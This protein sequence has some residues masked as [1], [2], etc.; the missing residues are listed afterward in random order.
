MNDQLGHRGSKF[1]YAIVYKVFR[2]FGPHLKKY[3]KSFLIAYAALV[4]AVLMNLVKPWPLKLIFDYILLDEPMPE[5]VRNVTIHFGND[6][7]VLL[8]IFCISIVIVVFLH[9]FFT[10]TRRYLMASA[11]QRTINDIRKRVFD[12]LHVLPQSF[13]SSSRSGDLVL[14]LTSDINDLKKLLIKSVESIATNVLTFGCTVFVM[15][16]MDWQLTLLAL[17]IAPSLYIISVRVSG[18]VETLT[19]EQRSKESEVASVVQESM[20][21]MP[22]VQAFTEEKQEKKRFAKISQESLTAGLKRLKVAR[23]FG[24]AVDILVA[25]GTALVVWY[26][27]RRVLGGEVT[28]GDL[29]VFSSYLKDLYGPI[30]KSS[31]LIIDFVSALVCGQ[32]ITEVLDTGI[33]VEDAPDA[34]EAPPFRGEVVFSNVTF[35]Y[36]PEKPVLRELSFTGKPG[37]IVALVGSSGTGKTTV[38]NLLLRF[39][40]PWDGQV[41]IDGYNIRQ[42]KL[43]SVRKQM[44]V[45]FQETLLFRRT[46]RENIVYGKPEANDEDFIEAAKSAQ[47][48]EFI[49]ELPEG[50]ETILEER[51]RNLSGGQRQ[52]IAL[53]RAILKDA[54]IL[55]LDE[56]VTGVDAFT[57]AQIQ[58]VLDRLIQSKTVF[59][60]AHRLSTIKKSDLILV[61]EEGKVVEQGTHAQLVTSSS[62]F[63]DLYNLQNGTFET[64]ELQGSAL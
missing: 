18:K 31:E 45:V 52:R 58:E 64:P 24:R 48:H 28:P 11:A 13:H 60:I 8:N 20:A 63:R 47:A 46:I 33:T 30:T 55:I 57:E 39:F 6:P 34:V 61:I 62:R 22:V 16:L 2:T 41:L 5:T 1:N 25:I 36:K 26:G 49:M 43:N 19:R 50:Y 38:V 51:G 10:Y 23:A 21:T 17:S 53:A 7:F 14:R 27:A 15:W 9:G 56:P 4:G 59:V 42:Y 44:S 12:H 54:P 37:Q 29:I 3:W 32:R 35:G 40:D